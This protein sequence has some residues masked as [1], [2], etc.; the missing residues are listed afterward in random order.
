MEKEFQDEL[1]RRALND[2]ILYEKF[3]KHLEAQHNG[4]FVA[5]SLEGVV[6][7][8]HDDIE[9]LQRALKEFRSGNFAFRR[10]GYPTMGKWRKVRSHGNQ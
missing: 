2:D 8:S 6:M 10:I 9:L 7:V 4:E 1:K 3:A 5:I